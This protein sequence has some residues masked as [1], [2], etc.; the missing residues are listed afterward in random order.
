MCG[1]DKSQTRAKELTV[2]SPPRVRSRHHARPQALRSIGITS[3][4][5]E[6]TVVPGVSV[7][8][9]T[10][11]LRVCGADM[12]V[13]MD[14]GRSEGSPPRVRSRRTAMA[15]IHRIVRITS[16]CAEQTSTPILS[17]LEDRDHLRVCGADH[18][19]PYPRASTYG[20]PPRVRS[21]P[22]RRP[23]TTLRL[24]ITSACAEQTHAPSSGRQDCR[25]HLRV[26]GAD[27]DADEVRHPELG[28]P[29]RVRSRRHHDTRH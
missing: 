16:A 23:R 10:D 4:C 8:V 11:H 25:D 19:P 6:Q 18:S 5:A 29:P 13:T 27:A 20:S 3:A 9:P 2:G 14:D 24:G 17:V 1:A 12:G 15:R 22:P 28:S 7:M 21:R 26:C